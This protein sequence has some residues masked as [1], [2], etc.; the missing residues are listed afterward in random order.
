MVP[1]EEGMDSHHNQAM[2]SQGTPNN[3]GI[4]NK[5]DLVRY[6]LNIPGHV[7]FMPVAKCTYTGLCWAN[8]V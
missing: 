4:H 1:P 8:V 7:S 6:I 2:D 5:E 3:Q